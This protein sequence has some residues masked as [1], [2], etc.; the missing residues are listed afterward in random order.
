MDPAGGAA[1]Q[2]TLMD[3]SAARF[4]TLVVMY[5]GGMAIAAAF[6]MVVRGFLRSSRRQINRSRGAERPDWA[7]GIW[8]CAHCRSTNHPS[9][10]RCT[11]CHAPR[12]DILRDPAEARP[13]WIP[14]RID[15]SRGLIV[16]FA[17]DPAAH[18]DPGAAHWQL[19]VGGHMVGSAAR[20]TGAIAL[21]KAL[22]G[23]ETIAIDV[24][25]T[26]AATYRLAD[27]IARF[28]APRFPIDVPCP[29]RGS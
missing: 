25:G 14:E 24:R 9:A 2:G 28:E 23:T 22:Q 11:S 13:D 18:S 3:E 5:T 12:A 8:L 4:V 21:L 20:R 10:R 26:G 27:A 15:A 19:L 7:P 16:T 29:E 6:F 1:G 17:H